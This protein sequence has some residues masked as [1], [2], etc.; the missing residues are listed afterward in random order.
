MAI[1]YEG[2][3]RIL[4][5]KKITLSKMTEDLKISSTTRSKFA[6]GQYVSLQTLELICKY[7]GVAI[8][9]IMTFTVINNT[10]ILYSRLNEEMIN[11]IKNGIYHE[12]Q[13]IMT[14]NSNHIEGSRLTFDQTRYIFETNTIGL[15]ND[16]VINID[17]LI[18]T[19][20]HF[21]AINFIIENSLKP[22]SEDMI[23]ELHKILKDGTS[24]AK[25]AWFNVGEYKSRPNTVGGSS[26]THPKDVASKMSSLIGLYENK[27]TYLFE[28]IIDFHYQFEKIH[29]FQDGNG[30]VG[31][32]IA[33]KE[34]LRHGIVPFTISD[35]LK[36]F[37]YHGLKEYKN[38]KGYLIDTCLTGQD[39]YKRLL[40]LYEISY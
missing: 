36:M 27:D 13:I 8:N 4:D 32:L 33:F 10:T 11:K 1:N 34:C 3:F 35:D 5:S 38:E 21:R 15:N 31:R 29:P 40:D 19:K 20:N 16:E 22:V 7:L 30:R 6:K 12:T 23:K 39:K 25:L 9:D 2:L 28:D 37:Y 26:T 17:D 18:E 24:D 14:F